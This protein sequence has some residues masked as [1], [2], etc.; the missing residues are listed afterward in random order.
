MARYAGTRLG[1]Q[2]FDAGIIEDRADALPRA[3]NEMNRMSLAAPDHR[4]VVQPV[5]LGIPGDNTYA[6][7][8]EANRA[9]W[10]QTVLRLGNRFAC[11]LAHWLGTAYG[12]EMRLAIDSDCIDALIPDLRLRLG[13][14]LRGS[15]T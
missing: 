11:A 13:A 7:Y 14:H 15:V 4:I 10:R 6:N 8:Q 3:L 1:R 12:P 5:L 2:E 9:L